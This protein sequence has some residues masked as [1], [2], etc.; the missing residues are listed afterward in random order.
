MVLSIHNDGVLDSMATR[1]RSTGRG[2]ARPGAGRPAQFKDKVKVS[3]DMERKDYEDL[4][5]IAHR[6]DQ[7]VTAV[8]RRALQTLLKRHRR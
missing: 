7:S 8:I 5:E 1:K 3:F 2:G 4:Q 6:W